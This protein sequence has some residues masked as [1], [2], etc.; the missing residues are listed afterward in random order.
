MAKYHYFKDRKQITTGALQL[1]ILL[2]VVANII[3][4]KIESKSQLNFFKHLPD[5]VVANIIIS[6]I[7]SKST[8]ASAESQSGDRVVANIIISK[9]ESKSQ[10]KI[11]HPLKHPIVLQAVVWIVGDDQICQIPVF[12]LSHMP[13]PARWYHPFDH[14]WSNRWLQCCNQILDV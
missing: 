4:S 14:G 3:I 1:L 6:K 9:I 10:N 11:L 5:I 2:V 12:G 8:T 7:E 13:T